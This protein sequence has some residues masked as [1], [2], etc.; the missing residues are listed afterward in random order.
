MDTNL[1]GQYGPALLAGFG[2]TILCWLFGTVAANHI[3][4]V[5]RRSP[6]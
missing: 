4:I 2:V 1:I 6:G 5:T 3:F